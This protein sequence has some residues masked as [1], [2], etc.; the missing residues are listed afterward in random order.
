MS[1][2]QITSWRDLPSLVTSRNGADIAKVQLA[3]RF[4]EAIDEAA[5][6]LGETSSDDYMAGWQRGPWIPAVGEPADVA[7]LVA[8]ELE[9]KWN[10]SA[11][12]DFLDAL[13]PS[14][15]ES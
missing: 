3:S 12:A 9:D 1:E 6:R 14:T 5:M 2:Y 11:I 10:A 7:G 4:Q 13:G 15:T 8:A